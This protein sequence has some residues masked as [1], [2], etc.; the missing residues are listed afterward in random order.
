MQVGCE[1]SGLSASGAGTNFHNGIAILIRL[2]R[3]KRHLNGTLKEWNLRLD[4]LDLLA[5]HGGHFLVL[6][7]RQLAVFNQLAA[8]AGE[9]FPRF[10]QLFCGTML[11]Q[12]LPSMRSIVEEAGRGDF[13]FQFFEAAALALDE[14]FKVHNEI[15][16][17]NRP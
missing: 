5:G 1:K 7:C 4:A 15:K 14:R 17:V 13:A 10:K 6:A 16:T 9:L 12:H 8:G 2:G 11:A 3:E